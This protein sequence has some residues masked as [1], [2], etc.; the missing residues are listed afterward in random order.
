MLV[1]EAADKLRPVLFVEGFLNPAL[2]GA[3][4]LLGCDFRNVG[5]EEAEVLDD[6]VLVVEEQMSHWADIVAAC[7]QH[8]LRWTIGRGTYNLSNEVHLSH[9]NHV[10]DA[11]EVTEHP[12]NMFIL[13]MFFLESC[14]RDSADA[15]MDG[16]FKLVGEIFAHGPGFESP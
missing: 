11:R 9:C 4:I 1:S 5:K 2:E 3:K 10:P 7:C 6:V 14:D 12:S 13:D 16:D 8:L 15:A